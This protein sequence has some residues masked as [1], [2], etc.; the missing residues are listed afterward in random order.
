MGGLGNQLFQIFTTIS[1][2]IKNNIPFR[3]KNED[4][5][6]HQRNTYWKSF[7]IQMDPFLIHTFPPPIHILRENGF[8][9]H[10][11]P[12]QKQT[13][14]C[15]L[16][17]YF[18]SYKYFHEHSDMIIRR[19]GFDAQKE[20]VFD[21]L[22]F[23]TDDLNRC[24]SMHFRLGDYKQLQQYHPL[25][26]YTYY[27]N[28]LGFIQHTTPGPY[29]VFYFCEEVDVDAVMKTICTLQDLFPAYTFLR[30]EATLEDWEQMMFM[31]GC[32]HNIIA[33]SS[34]SWWG[35]YLNRW[36]DKIVCYPS[37]WFGEAAPHDTKDL[38]PPEWTRIRV[39]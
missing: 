16:V 5:V 30:G 31:S 3:F 13:G 20:I 27:V 36:S 11:L 32:H 6:D 7:L 34:F 4:R 9:F 15:L 10:P 28:A 2:A 21:K 26:P 12:L 14:Y 19:F 25:M 38:C 33:N 39:K 22:Q 17:G 24:I 1:Y 37:I 29:T 23:K 8:A 18:Q 35:A